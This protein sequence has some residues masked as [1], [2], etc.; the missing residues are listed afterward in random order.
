G[1]ELIAR[2][3]A[4]ERWLAVLVTLRPDGEP[5]TSV[6]NAGILA[7]P[8]PGREVGAFVA[9]GATAKLANLR[10]RP[11]ATLVFR[12]GWE[13]V[14]VTGPVELVGPDHHLTGLAADALPRLP[15]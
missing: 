11:R 14:A 7:H 12:A 6:V 3:G 2:Y 13:W 10:R 1:L 8:V 5:S 15:P 9:R 4:R